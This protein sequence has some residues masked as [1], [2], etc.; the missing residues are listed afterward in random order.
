MLIKSLIYSLWR[1]F[2]LF[3]RWNPIIPLQLRVEEVAPGVED[4]LP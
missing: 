3:S 2:E 4:G 1:P